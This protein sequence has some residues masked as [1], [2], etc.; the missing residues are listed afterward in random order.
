MFDKKRLLEQIGGNNALIISPSNTYYVSGYEATFAYILITEHENYY[1]TDSRYTLEATKCTRDMKVLEGSPRTV[2]D[3]ILDLV[4][5]GKSLYVDEDITYH[6]YKNIKE[7][8]SSLTLMPL[9]TIIHEMRAVKSSDEIANI[10]KAE[11]IGERALSKTLGEIKEGMTE[12]EVTALLEYHMK[13]YGGDRL[14]FE[15]IVAFGENTASPHAHPGNRALKVGDFITIDYG[16][17]V[18]GYHGDSTRTMSFGKP[19]REMRKVY[20]IV[21][22]AGQMAIESICSGKNCKD[23]DAIARDYISGKGYGDAF[24]HGLGHS[25]GIDIHEDP[26]FAPG[27]DYV[28]R[29]N[30]V[31]TVEPGI[32]LAEKFGI[33]IEDVIIVKDNGQI[34]INN[35]TRELII[36]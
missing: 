30:N 18:N 34:D 1:I 19:T 4:D 9:G 31:I 13:S 14:S 28:L 26:R 32:Y 8:L 17:T 7:H 29:E 35:L 24:G 10:V 2:Y 33:R 3:M 22:T 20:D 6:E 36:L 11:S 5:A 25:V 27:F 21:N 23:I 16:T 12:L 15:T